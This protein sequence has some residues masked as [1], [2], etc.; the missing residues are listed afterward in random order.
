MKKS[1]VLLPVFSLP[2]KFGI[3]D[4]GENARLFVD[5]LR[6][7]GFSYWQILPLTPTGA[8]NGYSPYSSSSALAG[9]FL[10]IDPMFFAENGLLAESDL[11]PY[12]VPCSGKCNY[13]HA[14]VAKKEIITKAFENF[15]ANP[16]KFKS[17]K[18]EFDEFVCANTDWLL[19]Y[20]DFVTGKNAFCDVAWCDFPT[21]IRGRGMAALEKFRHEHKKYWDTVAF[22]QFVFYKQLHELFNYA[23]SKGV[24]IISDI[25]FYVSYDSSDV[26]ADRANFSLYENGSQRGVAGVPPDYFSPTGQRW[27]NP[28]YDWR[29]ME[30][31]NFSWWRRRIKQTLS[32]S[33]LCRI[34]H[35]RALEAYWRVDEKCDTAIDGEWVKTPGYKLLNFLK[36]DYGG[37]LPL[38]AEDL[39]VI[40]PPVRRMLTHFGL[41]GMK[42]LQFAF[43]SDKNNPY[44]PRNIKQDTICYTG[45]HDNNTTLGWC[46]SRDEASKRKTLDFLKIKEDLTAEE[47]A[48]HLILVCLNTK[49]NLAILPMQDILLKDDSCR[50]NI[51]GTCS[52]N[53]VW[54]MTEED[55]ASVSEDKNAKTLR[56]LNRLTE[57]APASARKLR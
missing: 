23:K 6:N 8:V 43:D 16:A 17:L 20:A 30:R 55:F 41:P 21:N 7:A 36:R 1:G 12:M 19:P 2:S 9:N 34:D 25:P 5:F 35:M 32:Y 44:L 42:V 56:K 10:F 52:G 53:W 49:S 38:I 47:L 22:A 4:F 31:D 48:Q 15:S 39:G 27:G 18:N 46:K 28:L 29:Y 45:T 11:L 3:G 14:T 13:E 50:T 54:Q 26:W 51:P 33:T 37:K 24:G 40:T 57:R